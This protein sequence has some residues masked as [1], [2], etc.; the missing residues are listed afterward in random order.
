MYT[1]RAIPIGMFLEARD[2]A[3]VSRGVNRERNALLA[4]IAVLAA[5]YFISN[6]VELSRI[7]KILNPATV[8]RLAKGRSLRVE[9]ISFASPP[10][11]LATS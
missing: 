11:C 4:L 1:D 8:K 10:Q 3:A 6:I 9:E 7:L 2:I 5:L